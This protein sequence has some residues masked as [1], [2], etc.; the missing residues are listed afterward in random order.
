MS[1]WEKIDEKYRPACNLEDLDY[2]AGMQESRLPDTP[3]HSARKWDQRAEFWKKERLNRRKGDERV[4]CAVQLLEQKGILNTECDI[5]DIGCGPGRFAAEFA[6]KAHSVLGLDISEKMVTHGMEYIREERIE[7]AVLKVCDFQNIDIEKEGWKEAFDLVFSSMTP[8]IHGMDGIIKCMEMSRAWCCNATHL[9]GHNHLRARIMK[10]VFGGNLPRQWSGRWFYSLFN[11]LFLMGYDPET[12]YQTRRQ[13]VRVTPDRDYAAFIMEHM[14]PEK[15]RTGENADKILAW[16]EANADKD[17]CLT[18]VT[19]TSYGTILWDIREKTQRPDYRMTEQGGL[20]EE[21]KAPASME[22]LCMMDVERD[23]GSYLVK[24]KS[25]RG[26]SMVDT[27]GA[28]AF[29]I[30]E[31]GVDVRRPGERL[32]VSLLRGEEDF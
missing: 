20:T 10:E 30:T 17:G 12:S 5:V 18:E 8:A 22:I 19:E 13:E 3:D 28:G 23:E 1:Y 7:N 29:Y 27:L 4:R 31:L 25:W 6:K 16:M 9:S 15:E 32:K 2:F 14:L 11:V 24:Q 21:I 26:G